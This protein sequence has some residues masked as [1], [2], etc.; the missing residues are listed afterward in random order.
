MI[1]KNENS[2]QNNSKHCHLFYKFQ[3][4]MLENCKYI[5]KKQK[6]NIPFLT[7]SYDFI[8][9]IFIVSVSENTFRLRL[10]NHQFEFELN[11][12]TCGRFRTSPVFHSIFFF[13]Y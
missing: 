2:Q 6:Q 9:T 3:N 12:L 13:K 4:G 1:H 5:E 10:V 7:N 11:G 8:P